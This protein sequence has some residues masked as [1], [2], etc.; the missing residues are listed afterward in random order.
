M[1][2]LLSSSASGLRASARQL[3]ATSRLGLCV[4]LVGGCAGFGA[5]CL[6]LLLHAVQHLTYGYDAGQ[7][8]GHDS[9]LQGVGMASPWRRLAAL[10]G[11]GL[12]AGAGWCAVYRW[13]RPLV[14][15]R[16]AVAGKIMP[17][18]S[19]LVHALLQI[20][21][22]GMGSPLGR[23][24]APRETGAL[25]AQGIARCFGLRADEAR[26]LVAC[27]AGAG[28]AAIYN[29]PFAGALFVLEV[30]LAQVSAAAALQALVA[31]G[32]ATWVARL[33]LGD[34]MQYH[35]P[36][37][38]LSNALL[39]WSVLAGPLLGAAAMAYRGLTTR[40]RDLAPHGARIVPFCLM[41]FALTGWLAMMFPGLPGNGKGPLQSV[42]IEGMTLQGAAI[43]LVLKLA[44]TAACL[45]A[46]AQGGLLTPGLT[47]GGLLSMVLA[48]GLRLCGLDLDAGACACVG[49]A[50]FLGVSMQM[51]LTAMMLMLGFTG[52]SQDFLLPIIMASGGAWLA[53]RAI[54]QALGQEPR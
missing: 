19:A 49:A 38:T 20:V 23:E 53:A 8:L 3:A 46:G 6:A 2:D 27:G 18:G 51:P 7:W 41:A 25:F 35:I 16:G 47:V 22:V 12:V 30:L 45:R 40:M 9:F 54:R 50:A 13:G 17:W 24:V 4:V 48:F 28:L 31:C 52:M 11:A 36:R 34:E 37:Y 39:V 29:V 21:T 10:T 14:S 44:V 33:G 1:S 42:L 15:V 5:M 43:M 26:V 32:T